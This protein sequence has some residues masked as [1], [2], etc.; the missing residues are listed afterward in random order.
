[1][2]FRLPVAR[3]ALA[4]ALVALAL[5]VV[6]PRRTHAQPAPIA[7]RTVAFT[8][9]EGTWI[10]L[11]V[12]PNGERIA[13]ELLGDLYTLP[14]SGG[15]AAPLLTGRSFES[16]PRYSPDG[17]QLAYVSDQ[18][19]SD[20]VWIAGADGS[21]ARQ[22]T[23]R[24][25]ALMISPEWSR[26]GRTIFV[27]LVDD[28]GPRVAELWRFDVATGGG[29]RVVENANGAPA[30]LI[31][32][33]APGAYGAA[34]SSDGAWLYFAS[35]TPRPYGSRN[36]A[37]S[38][39][40]RRALAGGAPTP[41]AL[42]GMFP[43]RPALSHDGRWLVY[44]AVRDGVTGLKVRDLRSGDERWLVRGIDRHELESRA[45]RDVVPGFDITPDG[46]SVV[47][48]FG[49]RIHRI[50]IAD[51]RDTVI[52]FEAAVS[53]EIV[54]P[55]AFPQRVAT[56]PVEARRLHHL[57]IAPDGRIAVS[58]LARIYVAA[59]GGRTPRRLT[60]TERPREF[61]PAWS[62][63]GHWIAFVTW[64]E[65][66]G[67]LWKA[68]ADGRTEPVQLS[69]TPAWYVD[70]AWTP[71]GDSIVA[72]TAT[73]G[74][75]RLVSTAVP[76]E[77]RLSPPPDARVVIVSAA[78]GGARTIMPSNGLRLPHFADGR[79]HLTS[80]AAGLV[81]VARDGS[82]RRTEATLARAHGR[83][84][85]VRSPDGRQVLAQVERRLLRFA[86]PADSA[87]SRELAIA[88]E[89]VLAEGTPTGMSWGA[90]GAT[91]SWLMGTRVVAQGAA[92]AR[93]GD[94]QPGSV[95]LTIAA[96]RAA[97][98]GTIVLRGARVL[99]MRGDEVRENADVLVRGDRVVAVLQSGRLTVP[100]DARIIDVR[101]KTIVPGF[102]DVHAHLGVSQE[103]LQPEWTGGFANLAYGITTARDP[104][105]VP[106]IFAVADIIEADGVPAPRVYSTG[107]GL[108]LG[109][110]ATGNFL[111][112][113][114]RSQDEVRQAMRRYRD[115]YHTPY[116]KSYLVGNRQQRQWV[117]EAAREF[118]IMPTTEGGAD[119]KAN[120][121]HAMDGFSGNEHAIPNAPI[122]DDV[123]QLIARSGIAYTP[124][125]IV[126]FGGALSI[127]R[128]LAEE[129]PHAT[130]KV[131]RWYPDGELYQRS[132]TRLLA[133]PAEDYNDRDVAAGAAAI[134]RAGG[135]VALGGH[136]EV[137]GL[138]NHWEMRLLAQGGLTP[139]EVL[140]IATIEGAR[141]LGLDADLGSIEAGKL[142]DLV[143][144]DRDPRED[145][146]NTT[147][148]AFVMK[149]GVLYEGETLARVWPTARELSWPWGLAR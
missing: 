86:M 106:D 31:S 37:S 21:S 7:T 139:M 47:A 94:G 87:T 9:S 116:L 61:M 54:P 41:V 78:T 138:S 11:D 89:T 62:P 55:L 56:G 73:L 52:P 108:T 136:G 29:E 30:P 3:L 19:G 76:A 111:A 13:F 60:R 2:P 67:H 46:A 53:L 88:A 6:A 137:Q 142:A 1:M 125:V 23:S 40:M 129:R 105:A 128:L 144:L 134:L 120:L 112:R 26:D 72:I 148:I 115:E 123:V 4:L 127:Y 113:D 17:T 104:Q 149:G 132:Q 126:A 141:T 50:T 22:L 90:D 36:G 118:G 77:M 8:T 135:R 107:P 103:L 64:D 119:A 95:A 97:A 45:T 114:F 92:S 59:P 48:A 133:F 27:T 146:R 35:V 14:I 71:A 82:A 18:S 15:R 96:P 99:T 102:I 43:M 121:T 83:G 51:G 10:S 44:A 58:T 33:P 69:T 49:G 24:R 131:N 63:D 100:P 12:A 81:S 20:N 80:P 98:G 122:Y 143:V 5:A 74:A 65:R 147:A 124:T 66:G 68:P 91:A 84:L 101:G 145:I 16:Q 79:L 117:V 42:E 39:I 109:E 140:R 93:V 130:P 25:R 75:T 34:L 57:A 28:T 32:S 70:P 85:L 110:G 38:T